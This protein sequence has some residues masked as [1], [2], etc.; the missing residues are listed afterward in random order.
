M[1]ESRAE[2][3]SNSRNIPVE[4]KVSRCRWPRKASNFDFPPKLQQLINKIVREELSQIDNDIELHEIILKEIFDNWEQWQHEE[5]ERS[6]QDFM[7][8]D[9]AQVFCPVCEKTLLS[10]DE[11]IISCCC[12]LRWAL[13]VTFV[14]TADNTFL[15]RLYYPKSL[16]DFHDQIL[17][18]VKSH[19]LYNCA[20]R[21]QFFTEPKLGFNVLALNAICPSCDFYASVVELI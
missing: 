10:L 11:N 6:L 3:F 5:Y 1:K 17:S 12:G 21:L 14:V 20:E 18:S 19:E 16:T 2:A 4:R 9:Q 8:M 15:C 13:E 7:Q